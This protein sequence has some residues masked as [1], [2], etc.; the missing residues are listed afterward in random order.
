MIEKHSG[1]VV[2]GNMGSTATDSGIN[3]R[4]R[5]R[6]EKPGV[7]QE[8]SARGLERKSPA[9]RQEGKPQ[10]IRQS[11]KVNAQI[12]QTVVGIRIRVKPESCIR[13]S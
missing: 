2:K 9:R 6:T 3:E 12:L 7:R 10:F 8:R 5:D 1:A 13:T 4:L 11:F